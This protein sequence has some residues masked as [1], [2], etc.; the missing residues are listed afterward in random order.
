MELQIASD[1][2]YSSVKA[3]VNGEQI[4][5]PSAI[6]VLRK[7]DVFDPIT[8]SSKDEEK[9]YFQ[10]LLDHMD[11]TIASSSV[12]TPERMLVGLAAVK[13]TLSNQGFNVAD[14]SKKSE[15]DLSLI[16]QLSM[17]ATSA[18][19]EAYFKG[20]NLDKQLEVTANLTT[21]LPVLEGKRGG[22]SERYKER[23]LNGAHVVTLH[24]FK[25]PI[26]VKIVFDKVIVALEGEAAR[27]ALGNADKRLKGEIKKDF[28]KH[29]PKLASDVDADYLA[30]A[31]NVLMIDIGEGTTD[32]VLFTDKQIDFAG[33][34][35]LPIGY[36]NAL[37]EAVS[38]L[39]GEGF[40][41]QN[42]LALSRFLSRPT[43]GL[44]RGRQEMAKGAVDEQ[45]DILADQIVTGASSTLRK[46][47]DEMD[48]IYVMGGGSIPLQK[49]SLRDKLASAVKAL[50][51]DHEIPIIW[52]GKDYAQKLNEYGM[53]VIQDKVM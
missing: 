38:Q 47:S 16:L 17:I 25:N 6:A 13:S 46:A 21:A 28:D 49:S 26:S 51:S 52:I 29:Y 20:E 22:A 14:L 31:P 42:R 24:N 40:F 27:Y 36:G 1:L 41:M 5:F 45:L 43:N 9:D 39:N 19:K 35:S 4:K 18:V 48:L 8:F 30:T 2:G 33:S 10:N 3:D 53:K 37:E 15:T 23:Y 32:L 7:Q 12:K 50:A 11:V 34:T 44:N